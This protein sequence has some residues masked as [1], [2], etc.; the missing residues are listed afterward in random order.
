MDLPLLD[1]TIENVII[2]AYSS[3][4]NDELGS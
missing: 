4:A 3:G 1:V 2:R